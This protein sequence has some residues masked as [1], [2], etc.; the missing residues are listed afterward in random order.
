MVQ[1]RFTE[2]GGVAA[3]HP[4]PLLLPHPADPSRQ[5]CWGGEAF[6]VDGKR[7]RV[8]AYEIAQSGWTE[9]LTRLH[10]VE[11]GGDHFIDIASRADALNEVKRVTGQAPRVVLEIGCSSGFLLREL[12]QQLRGHILIGADYTIGTLE[13][14]GRKLRDVP[15]L[16]FDLTRCPL[17]DAFADTIILLNVLEHIEDDGAAVAQLFRIVKPGGAVIIE[18]PA[19]SSL[20]D[21]YDRV[22]LHQRRYDMGSLLTRLRTVGFQIERSSH[23]GSLLYPGFYISKRLNQWRY[24]AGSSKDEQETVRRMI[25]KTKNSGTL[26]G[27]V[28]KIERALDKHFSLPF[29]IR[30]LAT[31]RK[32]A[33]S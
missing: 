30:C 1:P 9:E 26:L 15:L 13:S 24:A 8:L 32:P 22:L 31:A 21:V 3:D 23:L 7:E 18:V 27:A 4:S 12:Q 20:F 10:K 14:L 33:V 17:P 6:Q 5:V 2:P 29:G 19:G 11:A 28:M 16:R 25:V